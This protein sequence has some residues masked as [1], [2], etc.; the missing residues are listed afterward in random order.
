MLN[1]K[2]KTQNHSLSMQAVPDAMGINLTDQ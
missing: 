2:M 1:T